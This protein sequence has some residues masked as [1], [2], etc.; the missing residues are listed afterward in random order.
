MV[1]R[2]LKTSR[3]SLPFVSGFSA[4]DCKMDMYISFDCPDNT[5]NEINTRKFL[6]FSHIPVHVNCIYI[7]SI[8]NR[9]VK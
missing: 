4:E 7:S 3:F 8:I 6:L 9:S 2:I 5:I 1:I